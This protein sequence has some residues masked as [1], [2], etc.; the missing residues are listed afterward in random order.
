M[1]ESEI[2]KVRQQLTEKTVNLVPSDKMADVIEKIIASTQSLRLISLSKQASLRLSD[3]VEAPNADKEQAIK[4]Y[5]HSVEIVLEGNYSATYQF[6]K[7]LEN[8][9]RKVAFESFNYNVE[10]Y[11]NAEIRLIVS[12][13]SLNKE[14]IGG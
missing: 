1:L 2:E 14:W 5:R 12:T 10:N 13:L 11:P 8:M 7:S 6:L 3:P 9:E 4:L